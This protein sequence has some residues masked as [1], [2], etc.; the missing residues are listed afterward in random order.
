MRKGSRRPATLPLPEQSPR[1]R[2]GMVPD[3]ASLP[4]TGT[5]GSIL[6][7][8]LMNCPMIFTLELLRA[9]KGELKPKGISAPQIGQRAGLGVTEE[10]ANMKTI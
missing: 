9:S 5:P 6:A 7:C 10:A 3:P 8:P 2:L 1:S 4:A